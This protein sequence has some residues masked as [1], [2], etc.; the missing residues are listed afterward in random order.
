M[1]PEADY[2]RTPF[3]KITGEGRLGMFSRLM[4]LTFHDGKCVWLGPWGVRRRTLRTLALSKLGR[5]CHL[6]ASK[7]LSYNTL[8]W[9][10]SGTVCSGEFAYYADGHPILPSDVVKYKRLRES[11]RCHTKISKLHF[12]RVYSVGRDKRGSLPQ[13]GSSLASPTCRRIQKEICC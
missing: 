8:Q 11:C 5:F 9:R 13:A 6:P 7:H 3:G 10:S 1:L 2:H 4:V 12:G